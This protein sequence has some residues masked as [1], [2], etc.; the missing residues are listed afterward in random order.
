MDAVPLAIA[1]LSSLLTFSQATPKSDQKPTDQACA[2]SP[3]DAE[4]YSEVIRATILDQ[5]DGKERVVL[6]DQT[7]IASPDMDLWTGISGRKLNGM[8]QSWDAEAKTDFDANAKQHC[9]LPA[10]IEPRDRVVF[11]T[12]E[13]E[14][15]LF[16]N[17]PRDWQAFYKE[18]P[19]ASG[20]TALSAIGFNKARDKALVYI[21]NSCDNLCGGG[22]FVLLVKKEGKWEVIKTS[23]TWET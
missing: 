17:R 11:V 18:Y 1:I 13:Q 8:L 21:A 7:S 12:P 9:A 20:L 4:I 10:S 22:Y 2:T 14:D 5:D 19:H 3:D 15:A 23:V 6:M 16:P